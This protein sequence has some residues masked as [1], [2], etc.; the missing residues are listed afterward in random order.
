MRPRGL[1]QVGVKDFGVPRASPCLSGLERDLGLQAVCAAVMGARRGYGCCLGRW[2][3]VLCGSV[4]K[5]PACNA[6]H[7]GSSP[8]SGRSAGEGIGY[9]LQYSGLENPMG[10]ICIVHGVAKSQTRLSDFHSRSPWRAQKHGELHAQG[11][12]RVPL[13]LASRLPSPLPRACPESE[14]HVGPSYRV[15]KLKSLNGERKRGL[16]VTKTRRESGHKKARGDSIPCTGSKAAQ[17]SPRRQKVGSCLGG[18]GDE[19]WRLSA[20]GDRSPLGRREGSAAR[21]CGCAECL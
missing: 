19:R 6:G 8:G 16:V 1:G 5:E 10:C 7:P 9:P 11:R 4:C 2:H 12:A 20:Q 14:R 18:L 21:L 15:V 3:G 17:A 13:G